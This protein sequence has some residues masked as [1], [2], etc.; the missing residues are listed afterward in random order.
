MPHVVIVGGGLSGLAV[1]FRLK[2]LGPDMSVTVLEHRDRAGGNVGTEDH[3]GFRVETGPNGFL[4]RTPFV[5]RLCRDL[6]LS[7]RLITA[8]EAA[9]KN[10]YLFLDGKLRQLPGGPLGLLASPLL[11]LRGKWQLFTEPFRKASGSTA[12]ESVAEF[13]TRR[14][15]K[16]AADTFADAL[17]TGIH[18]G[19]SALLSVAAAFPRLPVM[20]REAGSIVRGFVR[21]AKQRKREAQAR[22]E[23]PPGPQR[24]WSFPEGLQVLTDSLAKSLGPALKTGIR[25]QAVSESAS[26]TPWKVYAEHGKAWSADAV[27]LACPAYEQAAIL[28]E[29]NP[30]LAEEVAGIPYNRIAVVALGYRQAD[31]PGQPDGFGYIAPQNTRRDVLGVQWCSS[32]YPARAPEGCVL[33]RALCGGVHR[34]EVVDWDDDTLVRAV[35]AEMRL[36]MGVRGEPVFARVIRWPAA[37]PQ[38]VVGHL[39][40]LA[41]IDAQVAR[42]PGL[43]LTGNAYRG[44]ALGDCAEHGELVAA[45]VA[46]FLAANEP[47]VG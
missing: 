21:A 17:V 3:D 43:F 18:G 16:E 42:H 27:V 38:Y 28:T 1:A 19:D 4:N 25:V 26:I 22:G 7:D 45:K 40:R 30:E 29:L 47:E 13:V 5:P 23:P 6:G 34:A 10:R 41:R 15:G 39:D 46:L 32:I 31:C 12:D 8:S 2:Q 24:M 44:V 20:E 33:W 9:R 14:A 37:I 36:A 11:S 35:H